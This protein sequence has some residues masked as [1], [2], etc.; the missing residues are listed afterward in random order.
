MPLIPHLA[1]ECCESIVKKNET[2]TIKWPKYDKKLL[3]EEEC[4]IVIQVDGKKR[5]ILKMPLN[6]KEN[7][8]LEKAMKIE[9]VMKNVENKTIIRNIFIKNKLINFI[10]R[11]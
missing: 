7:D 8:I 3:Q 11:K 10:T 2:N 1:S 4:S 9:N 6:V 5:G